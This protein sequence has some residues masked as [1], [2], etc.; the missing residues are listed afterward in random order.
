MF[1]L[2]FMSFLLLYPSTPAFLCVKYF[3][4]FSRLLQSWGERNEKIGQARRPN[5][6]CSYQDSAVFLEYSLNCCKPLVN[7]KSFE[8]IHFDSFCQC[9]HSFYGGADFQMSIP[10]ILADVTCIFY[11]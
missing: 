7:S 8:K 2:S 9:S 3:V 6:E 5:T 11:N 4:W 1:S 10:V